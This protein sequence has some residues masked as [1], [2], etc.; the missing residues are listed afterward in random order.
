MTKF[1]E[2]AL[3]GAASHATITAMEIQKLH[4]AF[5]DHLEHNV[6]ASVV[7]LVRQEGIELPDSYYSEDSGY[8]E[9]VITDCIEEAGYMIHIKTIRGGLYMESKMEISLMKVM[10]TVNVETQVDYREITKKQS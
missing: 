6:L 7:K 4:S 2:K 3:I 5:H 10:Q 9:D 8:D 1:G